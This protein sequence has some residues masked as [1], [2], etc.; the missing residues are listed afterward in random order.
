MVFLVLLFARFCYLKIGG[1]TG[2]TLGASCELA[3]AV[4]ALVF[5]IGLRGMG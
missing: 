2:D 5:T 4:V 1:A 3:E